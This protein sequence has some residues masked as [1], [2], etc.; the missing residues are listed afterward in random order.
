MARWWPDVVRVEGV[1][2]D[3]FTQVYISKRGRTVRM[4]F[5]VLASEPP[6]TEDA[7]AR[8]IW[9]QELAGTPFERVLGE[10]VTEIQLQ[11][12]G[13][14]TLV[15]LEHRQKMRGFNRSGAFMI[16]RATRQRLDQALEGL[17]RIV[18]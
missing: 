9:E 11:P 7:G 10:S 5:V 14:G 3:R 15:M 13:D 4:D 1:A 2:E 17:E 6:G 16:R 12:S 18:G 8:R